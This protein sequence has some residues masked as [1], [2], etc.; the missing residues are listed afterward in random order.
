MM[1]LQHQ[2]D[3]GFASFWTVSDIYLPHVRLCF[4]FV[5]HDKA[6]LLN[7]DD[8]TECQKHD[9]NSEESQLLPGLLKNMYDGTDEGLFYLFYILDNFEYQQHFN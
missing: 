3:G 2:P 7:P 5:L 6:T 1:Q 4:V 8:S 9:S